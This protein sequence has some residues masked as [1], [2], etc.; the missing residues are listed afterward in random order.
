MMYVLLKTKKISE[1][2]VYYLFYF[3]TEKN[4]KHIKL[5]TD[6]WCNRDKN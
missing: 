2:A 5:K 3:H 4:T 6:L 1:Q